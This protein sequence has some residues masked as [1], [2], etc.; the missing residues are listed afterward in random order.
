MGTSTTKV[1]KVTDSDQCFAVPILLIKKPCKQ[2]METLGKKGKCHN[3]I[4]GLE[5]H[6]NNLGM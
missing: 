4:L 5:G 6:R 3:I 1:M 2:I